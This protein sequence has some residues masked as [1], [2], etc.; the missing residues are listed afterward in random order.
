MSRVLVI[1][2]LHAP[3]TH[4][5]YLS[6]CQDIGE[7]W[8]CDRTVF[9]GD[10]ADWHRISRHVKNASSKGAQGEYREAKAVLAKWYKVFPDADVTEGNHDRRIIRAAWDAEIPED[11]LKT[12]NE[13]WGTPK[14]RWHQG[15]KAYVEIDG[16]HYTHG[17][18]ASGS[19]PALGLARLMGQ[20]V[21]CG[22]FHKWGGVAWVC[23]PNVRRFGMDTG[24]G[25]DD[26][27]PA[28]RYGV[29]FA[30]KCVL[31][32]GVVIDGTPYHEIMPCGPGEAYHRRRF[33][34]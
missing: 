28:M 26:Q 20:S 9:I 14:W 31:S 6:F 12:Y 23:R 33:K 2:D 13:L 25:I 4:P 1:G 32:C 30:N 5:G 22:H 10:V 7:A 17:T 21:V 29:E 27:H 18:T 24:C 11:A 15:D 34:R 8:G 3:A 16:V 19:Q